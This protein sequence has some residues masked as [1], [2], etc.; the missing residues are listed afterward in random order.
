MSDIFYAYWPRAF[1]FELSGSNNP[2]SL[3]VKYNCLWKNITIEFPEIREWHERIYLDEDPWFDFVT[4]SSSILTSYIDMTCEIST[5][6][7]AA[8]RRNWRK[9]L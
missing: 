9:R 3:T 4:V 1:D 5:Y 7:K 8:F 6:G 2:Y